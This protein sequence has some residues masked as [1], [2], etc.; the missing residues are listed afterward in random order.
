[1]PILVS[2]NVPLKC[3]LHRYA[4]AEADG[5]KDGKLTLSEM[6]F[7]AMAFYSTVQNDNDEYPYHDEFK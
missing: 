6:V 4:M 3:N 7:N 5:N 2:Q 1:M